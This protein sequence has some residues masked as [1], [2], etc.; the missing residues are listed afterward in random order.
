M[1]QTKF[2]RI[3]TSIQL[4][5]IKWC[6]QNN[7]KTYT[8]LSKLQRTQIYSSPIDVVFCI[9]LCSNQPQ[10][11]TIYKVHPIHLIFHRLTAFNLAHSLSFSLLLFNFTTKCEKSSV[12]YMY[13]FF[14]F[15]FHRISFFHPTRKLIRFFGDTAP[16]LPLFWVL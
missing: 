11:L 14:L 10:N 2:I 6:K 15:S 1:D 16:N 7:R 13:D 12:K 5:L 8:S 3:L 9:L 4:V